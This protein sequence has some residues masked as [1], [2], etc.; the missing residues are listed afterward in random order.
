MSNR[1]EQIKSY[2]RML[3][4]DIGRMS[5]ESG[6]IF[7]ESKRLENTLKKAI[8]LIEDFYAQKLAKCFVDLNK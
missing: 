3:E 7:N 5:Y 2:L 4:S 8:G 1:E 6:I